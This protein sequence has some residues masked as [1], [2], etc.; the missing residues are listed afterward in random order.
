MILR[1][2]LGTSAIALVMEFITIAL[3]QWNQAEANRESLSSRSTKAFTMKE[4]FEG[5]CLVGGEEDWAAWR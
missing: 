1:F 2:Y 4:G 5:Q 3:V